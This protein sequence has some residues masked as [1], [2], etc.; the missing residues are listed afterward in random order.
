MH[1]GSLVGTVLLGA[2]LAGAANATPP[3]AADTLGEI[4]TGPASLLLTND[5][6]G[7][8]ASLDPTDAGRFVDWFWK[9]R[10]PTPDTPVNEFRREFLERILRVDKDYDGNRQGIPGWRTVPGRLRALLGEPLVVRTAPRAY[11]DGSFVTVSI[12]EYRHPLDAG[13]TARFY[14]VECEEG[15]RLAEAADVPETTRQPAMLEAARQ[16]LVRDPDLEFVPRAA[17][18]RQPSLAAAGWAAP[19][20]RGVLASVEMELSDLAGA[21]LDDGILYTFDIGRQRHDRT[22][23]LGLL[24]VR[25]TTEGL[26][27]SGARTVQLVLWLPDSATAPE[28]I[29][30]TELPSGRSARVRVG[31]AP[32]PEVEFG[33]ARELGVTELLSGEGV[34]VAFLANDHRDGRSSTRLVADPNAT[35]QTLPG[36]LVLVRR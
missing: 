19:V 29:V 34:A 3:P 18:V 36:G 17:I 14:L 8:L 16:A 11:A 12:W 2:C 25:V 10:D 27:E 5:E 35:G 30:V 15:L 21:P 33:V 31:D 22:D 6:Q 28:N 1:R 24:Q 20:D 26:R 4:L 23:R 7:L 13:R 32:A 9:R